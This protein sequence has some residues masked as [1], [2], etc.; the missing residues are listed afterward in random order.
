MTSPQICRCRTNANQLSEML[1]TWISTLLCLRISW[2]GSNKVVMG[3]E[4]EVDFPTLRILIPFPFCKVQ[5]PSPCFPRGQPGMFGQP[6]Y[7]RMSDQV[8]F[9]NKGLNVCGKF[10]AKTTTLIYFIHLYWL[11]WLPCFCKF[12]FLETIIVYFHGL[13]CSNSFSWH[14]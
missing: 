11:Y 10:D 2:R 13:I 4:V 14:S 5:Y 1:Q 3:K 12:W 6:W 9:Q 8:P 7:A